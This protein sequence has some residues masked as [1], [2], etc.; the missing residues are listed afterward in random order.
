MKRKKCYTYHI[1][2]GKIIEVDPYVFSQLNGTDYH[3]HDYAGRFLSFLSAK[4]DAIARYSS[5]IE[6]AKMRLLRAKQSRR[7]VKK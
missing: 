3:H 1:N 6:I 5:E 4:R 2:D 7:G